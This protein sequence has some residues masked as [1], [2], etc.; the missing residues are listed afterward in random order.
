M[1]VHSASE[2]IRI[3]TAVLLSRPG[4]TTQSDAGRAMENSDE[5]LCLSSPDAL[6]LGRMSLD[7]S[8]AL[9]SLDAVTVLTSLDVVAALALLDVVAALALL[10]I[11]T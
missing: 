1:A 7:V 9:G 6:V 5:V 11:V 2:S 4:T 3:R 10:D 8:P